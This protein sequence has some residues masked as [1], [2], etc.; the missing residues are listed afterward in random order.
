MIDLIPM[1]KKF[2][3]HKGYL[4][5][6]AVHTDMQKLSER[7]QKAVETLPASEDGICLR[8]NF[9][10]GGA[11]EYTVD[12]MPDSIEIT[13]GADAGVF[14]A[15]QTIKQLF[16]KEKVPC[17]HIEDK[18][19]FKLRGFYHDVTRGR[20]PTL[21]TLKDLADKMA[22]Y[23][24][25]SLQL[26]VEHTFE[27]KEY[28][29]SIDKTGYLTAAEIRELDSY[30]YERFIELVPSLSTFGHLYELLQKDCYKHLREAEDFEPDTIFWVNRMQHHTIDPTNPESF[31]LIKSLLDQY[32]PLFRSDK[33]NICCDETFDLE[34]GRHKETYTSTL[35]TDFVSKIAEH[36][37]A[38]GKTVMMWADILIKYPQIEKNLPAGIIFLNWDYAKNPSEQHI[39]LLKDMHRPQIVCPGTSSWMGLT[40]RPEISVDN[41]SHMA[42]WGYK[43][44]AEG[45]L[46]TNWGDWGN[47]CSIELAMYSM[48]VGA[49]KSWSANTAID[50]DFDDRVNK[51]L[52]KTDRGTNWLKCLDRI[53]NKFSWGDFVKCYS[54]HIYK[55][56]FAVNIP[57]INTLIEIQKECDEFIAELSSVVWTEDE[58]RKEMLIA[59]EGIEVMA[60][61]LSKEN[62][63]PI[64]RHTDTGKWLEKYRKRWLL[65]NKESELREIE[66]VFI[67]MDKCLEG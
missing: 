23:K 2:V 5:C 51:L 59:A 41:I 30:C 47:P 36:V 31:A 13:A 48:L 65:K 40:E 62:G 39:K 28:A 16:E 67:T 34:R 24:L 38:K 12:I 26:Y 46:N 57:D 25:N 63:N 61:L 11:E 29:D 64:E 6:K 18:P 42:E 32:M 7:I 60:E 44:G 45:V 35:Y 66:R 9:A 8:V 17:C 33:F 10:K 56:R 43:Y 4:N 49:E 27:F 55:K 1:P 22:Y 37:Q 21:Q 58:Y 53:Q 15:V 3:E 19:D 52:Y 50:L 54:N 20:V 14:Y